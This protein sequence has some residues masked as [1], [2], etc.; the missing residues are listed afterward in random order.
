MNLTRQIFCR[1]QWFAE[2]QRPNLTPSTVDEKVCGQTTLTWGLG[3]EQNYILLIYFFP[4][5]KKVKK[6]LK[7]KK[8]F[9][10]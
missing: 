10:F 3:E 1:I 7:Q 5:I 4:I 2:P 6:R 8:F 9:I